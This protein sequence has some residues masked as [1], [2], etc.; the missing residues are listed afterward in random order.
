MS[1]VV[2]ELWSRTGLTK[3]NQIPAS[4]VCPLLYLFSLHAEIPEFQ[5]FQEVLYL[6]AD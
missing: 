3:E 4:Q 2:C 5:R 6:L 1:G